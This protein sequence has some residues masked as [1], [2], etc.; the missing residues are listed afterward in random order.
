MNFYITGTKR[1]LGKYLHDRLN[2]VE[3]LEEC[4]IFINCKHQGFDQV[5]LLYKACELGKRVINI[6][7]N[8]G[9]GLKKDPHIYAVQK[10]AL[11]KANEQLFYQGYNVTSLRLG[12]IDTERVAE[13]NENK[14]SCRSVLDNIEWILLHPHRI[15][16]MTITP[17]L[18]DPPVT[19]DKSGHTAV[20]KEI[21]ERRYDEQSRIAY[22][23]YDFSDIYA[24]QYKPLH[25]FGKYDVNK[26]LEEMVTVCKQKDPEFKLSDK[27]ESMGSLTVKRSC[28]QLMLQSTDGKDFYT[29]LAEVSKIP[30]DKLESDF[31]V[32]NIPE[33]WETARFIN[34]T[35]ITRARLMVMP[36]KCC[37]TYH[38][39]PTPRIHIVLKTNDWCFLT[40]EN[41]K[42]FHV[43]AD[44]SAYYFDATA[45]HSAIN[46]SLE[47]R[48]H[49][50]GR[51]PIK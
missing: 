28:Y 3:T 12:W 26:M 16:E 43:P 1:G 20:V 32:L 23:M 18:E 17:Y 13:I 31:S 35:G 38:F 39:D 50:M 11:D 33:D 19:I 6:S 49:I 47:E 41:M 10:A 37:Y 29:G 7:S 51:A 44:G 2:V 9:D 34:D 4:D 14:M 25:Q 8:S 40:N 5:D 30:K 45:A 36:P 24:R 22:K 15:K 46:S 48:I 27:Q 21:G 42:L